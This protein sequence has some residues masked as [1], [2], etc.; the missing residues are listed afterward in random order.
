MLFGVLTTGL[1]IPLYCIVI[2]YNL[3]QISRGAM[4]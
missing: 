3:L 4:Q 2:R 1:G